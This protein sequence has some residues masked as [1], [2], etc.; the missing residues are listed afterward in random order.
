MLMSNLQFAM[1]K[2]QLMLKKKGLHIIL[3]HQ[4][5][6]TDVIDQTTPWV[7]I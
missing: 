4:N 7:Q 2:V 1:S 5:P 6:C 3:T